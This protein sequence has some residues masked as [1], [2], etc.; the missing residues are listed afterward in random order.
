MTFLFLQL[1]LQQLIEPYQQTTPP[2]TFF[3]STGD[4]SYPTSLSKTLLA[5]W[6]L[7]KLLFITL[8]TSIA[9][10]IAFSVISEKTIRREFSSFKFKLLDKCHAI[11]S[12]SLSSSLASQTISACLESFFNSLTIFFLSDEII[13]LGTK[14]PSTST[15]N[16]FEGKSDI[17]PKQEATLKSLPKIFLLF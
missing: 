6:A 11:A 17:C 2:F 14:L 4:N 7:T 1:I 5:C 8:G 3:Q 9:L 10:L 15:P 12:P 13:Y 16:S